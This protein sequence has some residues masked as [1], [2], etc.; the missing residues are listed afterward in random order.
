[1]LGEEHDSALLELGTIVVMTDLSQNNLEQTAEELATKFEQSNV[2]T[3]K[4]DVT[5]EQNIQNVSDFVRDEF[6]VIK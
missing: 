1:M 3:F 6:D 2:C 5:K 4:M